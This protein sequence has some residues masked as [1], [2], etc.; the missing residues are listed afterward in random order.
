VIGLLHGDAV[1]RD[2]AVA[3]ELD[4]VLPPVRG[5]RIQLQ[6]VALNL[7]VNAFEA[8]N[9]RAHGERRVLV[10]TGRKEA[11]ILAAVADTGKGIAAGEAEKIF[12]PFYTSKPQGLGMGLSICRSIINSHRG[13]L[14]AENNPDGGATFC[15]SLPTPVEEP[16]PKAI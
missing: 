6:Q 14:W 2:I 13:R 1:L 12:K 8:M 5:D 15:F 3:I 10:R 11:Q 7:M 4:P 9:E 16:I